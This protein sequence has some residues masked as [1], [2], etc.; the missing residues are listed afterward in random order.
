MS[1]KA[2]VF[3]AMLLVLGSS[4]LST[5]ALARGGGAEADGFRG[6]AINRG[7]GVITGDGNGDSSRA[8]GLHG[9]FPG[10]RS[11]DVWGHWGAYYGPMIPAI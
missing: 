8:G 1:R 5:G 11:R 7:F 3:L 6:N 9:G 4:G 10:Y 2:I